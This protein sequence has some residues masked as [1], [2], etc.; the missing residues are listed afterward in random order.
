MQ[1]F[2][3][4]AGSTSLK[5]KLIE[6]PAAIIQATGRIERIGNHGKGIYTYED[7][8][9]AR[10][11]SEGLS[12]PTYTD[13]LRRFFLDLTAGNAPILSDLDSIAAVAYKTVLAK[14]FLG[15]HELTETVLQGMR[16]YLDIAPVHNSC[17]LEVI[18]QLQALL[19][20]CRHIGVFET[21]F[22]RT[23]PLFARIYSLPYTWYEQYGIQRYGFHGASHSYIAKVMADLDP[24]AR[25]I[26][27]CHLG[28]SSSICAIKDGISIDT[29]FGFSLQSGIPHANR[30]GDIDP[31]II[32][33][34]LQKGHSVDDLLTEL[35][36]SAGLLG[37]SGISNDMRDI[38]SQ[39]DNG[40]PRAKL[41]IAHYCHEIT[42]FVGAF[43]AGMNGLDAIVFTAG[44][45]EH[46]A[47]IR[48]QVCKQLS[49]LGLS[50]DETANAIHATR[51]TTSDST[52]RAYVIPANEEQGVAQ[53][54]Y[55]YLLQN[56][57]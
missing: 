47:S 22:H 29:S 46:D 4:N 33:F 30:C 45:G 55:Q 52:V 1:I 48:R 49:F 44:I 18:S 14:G 10:R 8:H 54:A 13:G 6:L 23:I 24:T 40:D 53:Q 17:Y 31:Y 36:R 21:A 2:V 26:V 16:D 41:A 50:L 38:E 9:G 37:L 34:L 19:P 56:P 25:R 20:H 28:G 11:H 35:S 32:P 12:V 27:S 57:T 3:C 15:I 42:K 43:A 7:R 5:L 51:I 39:A